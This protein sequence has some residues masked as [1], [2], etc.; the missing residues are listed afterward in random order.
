MLVKKMQ[1]YES[2][3]AFVYS[4]L[5][6]NVTS[7]SVMILWI[8]WCWL[9]VFGTRYILVYKVKQGQSWSWS[10]VAISA[11]HPLRCVFEPRSWWGVLDT[12]LCDKVCQ[13]LVTGWWFSTSTPV[14]FTN[15]TDRHNISEILLKVVL[16]TMNHQ[17]IYWYKITHDTRTMLSLQQPIVRTTIPVLIENLYLVLS[18]LMK[19]T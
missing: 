3:L 5:S 17:P 15:I 14:S 2:I 7:L 16:N 4:Y 9:K 19:F 8:I 6:I 1:S 12:T 13:W 10:H 18:N 11:Y